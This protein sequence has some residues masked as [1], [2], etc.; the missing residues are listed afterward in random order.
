MKK[1]YG[2]TRVSTVKQGEG[3][4]LAEQKDSIERYALKN[5]LVVSKWFE[6]KQT[7]AKKGRPVF[8]QMLK[9]LKRKKAGGVVIHKIDRS[10]RN[11]R[12]W[13]DL[14]DL[15]DL[16]IDVHFSFESIDFNTRGGRLSADIQA[17]IA[18]DYIRNLREETKKGLYGRLKQ[19][20]YPY[21][22]P[23]GYLNNGGGKA[24]TIDPKKGP[25]VKELFEL[26][27]TGL[28]S[29][30]DLEKLMYKKGLRNSKNGYVKRQRISTILRNPFYTGVIK[31]FRTGE[32]YQGIH[33]PLV[34]KQLFLKVQDVISG[35]R[36]YRT[37]T[38]DFV[39]R[40][41]IQCGLCKR[42]LIS[43]RQ[44]G[45]VYYRCRTEQCPT[46]TVREEIIDQ[47]I[48]KFLNSVSFTRSQY[49]ELYTMCR[50][51][52]GQQE[53]LHK[54]QERNC[55]LELTQTQKRIESLTDKF[56]DDL[57]DEQTYKDTHSKLLI[58]K[59]GLEQR[60]NKLEHEKKSNNAK[61]LYFLS[62]INS[63]GEVYKNASG[64]RKRVMLK[65]ISANLFYS[66]GKLSIDSYFACLGLSKTLDA[67]FSAHSRTRR[68]KP[69]D[70]V[71]KPK[72]LLEYFSKN[73]TVE[74][75]YTK[76]KKGE[77]KVFQINK[78]KIK[79]EPE[80]YGQY[81]IFVIRQNWDQCHKVM[82]VIQEAKN[83][84]FFDHDVAT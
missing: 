78:E 76:N 6:E 58:T 24:K 53:Q 3:V 79:V 83:T 52:I 4:S 41:C 5:N 35:K 17:V 54:E 44:K 72:K 29:A 75:G 32:T 14:G 10:A 26:Y 37:K 19:G 81:L 9:L 77:F 45:H 65:T 62:H 70:N 2:Y 33:Q 63:L 47:A 20:V 28:Y 66:A 40:R 27:S 55:K 36:N 74:Y 43:E 51:G 73:N 25:L 30:I 48:I 84:S 12:D 46:K 68:R 57:V 38:H 64:E 1:V 18:A 16:G 23:I 13:A 80:S 61:A 42:T 69:V 59:S 39:Y 7:A 60:L 50:A 67:T 8:T 34:S 82:E 22:A 71:W 31:I 49:T 15:I 21:A 56:V 11:L